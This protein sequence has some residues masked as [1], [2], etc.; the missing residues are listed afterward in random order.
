MKKQRNLL[1]L[2][3]PFLSIST[4]FSQ[5]SG[6]KEFFTK[7][8]RYCDSSVA[9]YYSITELESE[10]AGVVSTFYKDGILKSQVSYSCISKKTKNGISQNFGK[11]GKILSQFTYLEGK[12]NGAFFYYFDT[13]EINIQGKYAAD[14]LQDSLYSYYKN[15]ASRRKDFYASGK[16]KDGK[17]FT[18][19][20][21]DTA[22]FAY[23]IDAEFPDGMQGLMRWIQTNLQYPQDAIE[24]D[25]Q[26]RVY[27]SFIVNKDG[28]VSDIEIERGVTSILDREVMRLIGQMPNWTPG[29]LDGFKTNSKMRLPINFTLN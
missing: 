25:I 29:E 9:V 18:A 24:D 12:K 6:T 23:E 26:G 16:L 20:G 14:S 17:C 3:I 2:V 5:I 19:S 21:L 4:S 8:W 15:G 28:V 7:N 1:L 13:G 22:Y 11:E 10:D 27:V